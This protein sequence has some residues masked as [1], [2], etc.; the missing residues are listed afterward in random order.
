MSQEYFNYFSKRY[1]KILH[2]EFGSLSFFVTRLRHINMFEIVNRVTEEKVILIHCLV[3]K[4][5]NFPYVRRERKEFLQVKISVRD[6]TVVIYMSVT[7]FID[8]TLT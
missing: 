6:V 8:V 5:E 7:V 2:L 1:N 3:K 4:E